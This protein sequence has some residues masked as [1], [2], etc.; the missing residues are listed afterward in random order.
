MKKISVII[1]LLLVIPVFAYP[2]AYLMESHP[3]ESA[4][5]SESPQKVSLHFLGFLEHFF[6][7]IEVHDNEGNKVSKKTRLTDGEDG[8]V[9]DTDLMSNLTSGEYTVKWLCISKDGH[10]QDESYKFT[11]K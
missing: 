11:V 8:T 6:S 3:E 4:M 2:H 7:R 5:L 10:R 1:L 9:M